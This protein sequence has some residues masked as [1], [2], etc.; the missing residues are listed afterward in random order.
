[1]HRRVTGRLTLVR[2]LLS[3]E[4]GRA[5]NE[6]RENEGVLHVISGM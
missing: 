2:L 5:D 1:M 3:D 4:G 6:Q